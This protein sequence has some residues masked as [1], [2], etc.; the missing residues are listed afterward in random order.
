MVHLAIQLYSCKVCNC[1]FTV[2]HNVCK[3]CKISILT[4]THLLWHNIAHSGE[5]SCSCSVCGKLFIQSAHI[6]SNMRLLSGERPFICQIC[7]TSFT[8]K[9]YLNK[10][11][12]THTEGKALKCFQCV[13][14]FY[15]WPLTE[16]TN[17]WENREFIYSQCNNIFSNA[18]RLKTH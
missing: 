16:R 2:A 18:D 5:A 4:H 11:N 15:I 1:N 3:T 13:K 8:T 17:H 7:H 9:Y 10:H 14:S 6:E 12:I